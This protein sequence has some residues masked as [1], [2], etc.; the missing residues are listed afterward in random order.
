LLVAAMPAKETS[1]IVAF[2]TAT[3]AE[4]PS[5]TEL[6]VREQHGVQV[7]LFWTR[8]INVLALEVVDNRND[9]SFEFVLDPHEPPLDVFYHP[10]AYAAKRG[11]GLDD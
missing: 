9:E 1:V 4:P 11:I 7:T 8:E 10:Y 2:M 3:L 5:R 6:A